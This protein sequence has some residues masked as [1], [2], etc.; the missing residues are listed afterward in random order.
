VTPEAF[1]PVIDQD[2][3]E[4]VQVALKKRL[5]K[6]TD[7]EILD[8]LRCL[9][10]RK[11]ELT[12]KIIKNARNAP[13]LSTCFYR[14]GRFREIYKRV[15]YDPPAGRFMMTESK[16]ITWKLRA[17]VL[18]QIAEQF[19]QRAQFFCLL[20]RQRLMVQLDKS[21]T[22]SLLMCRSE[23]TRGGGLGWNMIPAPSERDYI[24]LLCRLNKENTGVH[25]FYLFRRIDKGISFKVDERDLWWAKGKRIELAQL[26]DSAKEMARSENRV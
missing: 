14:L 7:E 15:G 22:I 16:A 2:T 11:G 8:A 10:R 19:P 6:K 1:P 24:T 13:T 5:A 26:C 3:F 4:R 21:L 20:G 18:S 17:Q 9:F 25:S 23:R 12:E